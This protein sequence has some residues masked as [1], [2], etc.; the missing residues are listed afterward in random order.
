MSLL[1]L[2][3][4]S[5]MVAGAT[6]P[7]LSTEAQSI[8]KFD[9]SWIDPYVKDARIV[10]IGEEV[11][12]IA[13]HIKV[14]G[15][16]ARRLIDHH[17]FTH[18]ALEDDRYKVEALSQMLET[19]EDPET[20]FARSQL[21]WCWAV[22][23]L[24]DAISFCR[25][26]PNEWTLTGFDVQ[27]PMFALDNLRTNA[28]TQDQ[29]TQTN[30]LF[31]IFSIGQDTFDLEDAKIAFESAEKAFANSPFIENE[32]VHL[33][34]V[35]EVWA[36]SQDHGSR[37]NARDAG[38]AE[39]IEDILNNDPEARIIIFAHNAHAGY[40]NYYESFTGGVVPLGKHVADRFQ[41]KTLSIGLVFTTGSILLDPR[42]REVTG[43]TT[44]KM[45]QLT[46]DSQA[47]TW[48]TI[49]QDRWL[50]IPQQ[51]LAQNPSI[52]IKQFLEAPPPGHFNNYGPAA[53]LA[54]SYDLIVG[55]K[56]VLPATPLTK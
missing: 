44:E 42:R 21:F 11:H 51:I 6:P 46:P 33:R 35:A 3:I 10:L 39:T 54:E 49:T 26:S 16:L 25:N 36:K 41:D 37:M 9:G 22:K 15:E 28:T 27:T 23:E 34:R 7:D 29:N 40:T 43:T 55:Y 56:N 19:D 1:G 2:I 12:G 20:T 52:E 32:F 31:K 53:N 13:E 8:E 18:I 5:S 17:G 45:D 4:I 48:N 14:K 30:L 47:A 50:I 38:M 24:A